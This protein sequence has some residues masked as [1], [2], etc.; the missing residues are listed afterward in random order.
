MSDFPACFDKS[1]FPTLPDEYQ[2]SSW[3]NSN[4]RCEISFDIDDDGKDE[5]L[6]FDDQITQ[7]SFRIRD[8]HQSIPRYIDTLKFLDD[9]VVIHSDKDGNLTKL[10]RAPRPVQNPW[11]IQY[12]IEEG[13]I[14]LNKAMMKWSMPFE[15][16]TEPMSTQCWQVAALYTVTIEPSEEILAR[17]QAYCSDNN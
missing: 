13:Y 12:K 14:V 5:V 17:A 16:F 9:G 6:I 3:W 11:P 4:R 2:Q 10:S 15:M 7:V 1:V 8:D